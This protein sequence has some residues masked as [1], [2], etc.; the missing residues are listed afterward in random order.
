MLPDKPESVPEWA[1]SNFNGDEQNFSEWMYRVLFWKDWDGNEESLDHPEAV[2]RASALAKLGTLEK[3]FYMDSLVERAMGFQLYRAVKEGWQRWLPAEY[4]TVGELLSVMLEETPENTSK[5]RDLRYLIET[6]LP[7]LERAGVDPEKLIAIP[8]QWSKA[9]V[10]IPAIRTAVSE[11]EGEELADEIGDILDKIGD[12]TISVRDLRD[13]IRQKRYKSKGL[14][15]V[16]GGLVIGPMG[17]TL[18]ISNL[19]PHYVKAIQLALEGIVN[20]WSALGINEVSKLLVEEFFGK[21]DDDE[22]S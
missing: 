1:L 17:D 15:P 22:K 20:E 7:A 19:P 13:Q 6:V 11:K 4:S 14:E 12:K 2:Q 5:Y 9:R 10:S 21:G 8:E 16:Q 18:I 3:T